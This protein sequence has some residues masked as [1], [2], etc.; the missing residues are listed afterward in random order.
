M[1]R[2]L[3]FL[4]LATVALS[5]ADSPPLL[6]AVRSGDHATVQKLL[7]SGADPNTADA[8]GTTALMHATIES[9]VRMMTLLL[10]RGAGI[11]AKNALESTVLLY[12]ATDLA[13]TRL[14]LD[15]GAGIRRNG[16]LGP[17]DRPPR[18]LSMKGIGPGEP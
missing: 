3:V 14:L 11:N 15:R 5:G 17:A 18:Q 7:A 8:D 13:K 4:L 2:F 9:D 12:A 6:L 1:S 16:I 10:D